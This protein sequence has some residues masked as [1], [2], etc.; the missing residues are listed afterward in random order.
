MEKIFV[1]RIYKNNRVETTELKNN[2][3][4]GLCD[5]NT[6]LTLKSLVSQE[7]KKENEVKKVFKEII[8]ENFP[9]W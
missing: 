4:R 7:E 8:A 3:F 1:K 9:N 2:S 6:K 5:R